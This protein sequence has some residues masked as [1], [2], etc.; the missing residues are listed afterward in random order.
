MRSGVDT[1]RLIGEIGELVQDFR[2]VAALGL[3]QHVHCLQRRRRRAPDF[4]KPAVRC[5]RA[6]HCR[7]AA[8][9]IAACKREYARLIREAGAKRNKFHGLRHTMATMGAILHG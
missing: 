6:G 1:F 2:R 8:A 5:R 9:S 4:S 7:A 3:R